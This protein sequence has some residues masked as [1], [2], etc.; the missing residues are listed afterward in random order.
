MQFELLF[1]VSYYYIILMYLNISNLNLRDTLKSYM[2]FLFSLEMLME[3]I[4][5][6]C[7]SSYEGLRPR[8]RWDFTGAWQQFW[9]DAIPDAIN[10]LYGIEHRFAG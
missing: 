10:D 4:R 7:T 3:A 8:A 5:T 1:V 6:S 2:L 9:P